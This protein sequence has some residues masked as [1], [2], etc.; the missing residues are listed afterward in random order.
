M[1]NMNDIKFADIKIGDKASMSKTITEY[2]VYAFAGI[3]GNFNPVHTDAEFAKNTVFKERIAHGLLSAGLIASVIGMQ[4]PGVNTIY[5]SQEIA[6]KAP[7]KIGDTLT[8]TVEVV[9]KIEQKKRIVFK[10]EVKNQN[11][12]VVV[13]GKDVVLKE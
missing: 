11:S 2:D 9:E 1:I 4:L 8:A 6:F 5:I 12:V 13:V 7:V 3:S 10:T